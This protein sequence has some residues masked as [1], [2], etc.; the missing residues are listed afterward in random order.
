MD[1]NDRLKYK[2]DSLLLNGLRY[3]LGTTRQLAKRL[4]SYPLYLPPYTAASYTLTQFQAEENFQYFKNEKQ[5]RLNLIQTL[6]HDFD[7]PLD[8]HAPER[9]VLLQLDAWAYQQWPAIYYKK[10]RNNSYGFPTHGRI[11]KVKSFLYDMSILLGE[12]YISVNP[13][14]SWRLY[15]ASLEEIEPSN[16]P[17]IFIPATLDGETPNRIIEMEQH[18][19]YHYL[20]QRYSSSMLVVDYKIGR[21]LTQP[22]IDYMDNGPR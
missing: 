16:C 1:Y 18:V 10:I 9:K 12:C 11:A 6:L 21:V 3:I 8:Y 4:S 5:R 14:S 2:S 15:D 20:A 22:I 7:I 13:R 19:I 17:V